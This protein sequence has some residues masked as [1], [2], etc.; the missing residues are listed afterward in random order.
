[1]YIGAQAARV[2]CGAQIVACEAARRL[3]VETH[4]AEHAL[5]AQA[6]S[7]RKRR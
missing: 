6:R 3:A 1:M 5:E 4:E 2:L 7:G